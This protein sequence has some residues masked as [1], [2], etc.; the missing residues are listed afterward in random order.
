LVTGTHMK[1]ISLT[2]T[3][4]V[5][6]TLRHITYV[7]YQPKR[8]IQLI[9]GS[10]GSG[11]SSLLWELSPLPADPDH[12]EKSGSKVIE[13]EHAGETYRMSSW[14][15][16]SGKH[17]CMRLRDE[18]ELNPGNTLTVQK[19]LCEKLFNYNIAVHQVMM[20]RDGH[21]F[22]TMM[23]KVRR[24]WITRLSPTDFDY[25][26][27]IFRQVQEALRDSSGS[28]KTAKQMLVEKE[29]QV[30]SIVEQQKLEREIEQMHADLQIMLELRKPVEEDSQNIAMRVNDGRTRLRAIATQ[31]LCMKIQ[32]PYAL[33]GEPAQAVMVRN[34]WGELTSVKFTSIAHVSEYI[35]ALKVQMAQ[36]QTRIDEASRNHQKLKK[37]VDVL[38]QTGAKSREGMLNDIAQFKKAQDEHLAQ[39]KLKDVIVLDAIDPRLA[40]AALESVTEPLYRLLADFPENQ[41]KRFSKAVK[42]TLLAKKQ[43]LK[44]SVIG[45]QEKINKLQAELNHHRHHSND[46]LISCP[47]CRH[48]WI[49]GNPE[50]TI[51]ELQLIVD[52]LTEG[53]KTFEAQLVE[54]DAKLAELDAYFAQYRQFIDLTKSAPI[55]NP[56]WA[57]LAAKQFLVEQPKRI[58]GVVASFE[59]DLQQLREIR[60]LGEQIEET[61]KLMAAAA[62]LGDAN[63]ATSQAELKEVESQI[64]T[65]TQMLTQYRLWLNRYESY[66][67]SLAEAESLGQQVTTLQTQ[68]IGWQDDAIETLRREMLNHAIRQ[69]QVSLNSKEST[70]ASISAKR[71]EV[72]HLTNQIQFHEEGVVT[73]K[74]MRDELSPS[75]GLIAKGLLGFVQSLIEE[76]NLTIGHIW[77]YPMTIQDCA[78]MVDESAELDFAFPL[79]VN[80]HA[81]PVPDIRYSS[82]GQKEVIDLAFKLVVMKYLNLDCDILYL[83]EFGSKMDTA[84]KQAA[85]QAITRIIQDYGFGQVFMVSHDTHI[86]GALQADVNVLDAA[87]IITPEVYNQHLELQ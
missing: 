6:M 35:Q 81:R 64:E 30:T 23:P 13:L 52:P 76:M 11:K 16:P 25:A 57:Y 80:H 68:L 18:E 70:L 14:F 47:S 40:Q 33:Y 55:L 60:K 82:E 43:V 73:F 61:E 34:D 65:H 67:K 32:H 50:K 17:S 39:C 38:E 48:Q 36:V 79:Q 87:N 72:N 46:K 4:N 85:A 66:R 2:L 26:L 63:L 78:S 62:G 37:T 28:L 3:G 7:T 74:A 58:L 51:K 41:D 29:A 56:L 10:N 86:H 59:A 19:E 1:I 84:H 21:R 44:D 49:P 15:E 83:D 24:E 31:L 69:F 77:A 22:S 54:V 27:K 75:E 20:G 9:L 8:D 53:V 12:Y 42:E 71:T 5:K 45:V